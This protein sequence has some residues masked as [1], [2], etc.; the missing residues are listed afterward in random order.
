[1]ELIFPRGKIIEI[2]QNSLIGDSG[3][4]LY[5]RPNELHHLSA[6]ARHLVN[7][8][9][10]MLPLMSFSPSID[11]M[12]GILLSESKVYSSCNYARVFS[13][14]EINKR[15]KLKFKNTNRIR[16]DFKIDKE[17]K[18]KKAIAFLFSPSPE[19]K[20]Q[21]NKA[22]AF[23]Q[24]RYKYKKD[25]NGIFNILAIDEMIEEIDKYC[26]GDLIKIN[27]IIDD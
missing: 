12:L 26:N 17:F 13:P 24:A 1:M 18:N 14:I 27:K 6:L 19:S 25:K 21:L 4:C 15:E 16:I 10:N 9:D 3:W 20:Y 7:W 23:Y 8:L 5:Y 2:K 22:R 11:D